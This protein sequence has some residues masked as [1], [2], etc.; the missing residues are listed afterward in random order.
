[1][2]HGFSVDESLRFTVG[3][4]LSV[5][6]KITSRDNDRVK[7]EAE[8]NRMLAFFSV[9]PHIDKESARAPREPKDLYLLP[10]EKKEEQG[11]SVNMKPQTIDEV[12]EWAKKLEGERKLK[13][14][15]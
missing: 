1:M 3:G 14:V 4:A 5:L 8:N 7:I 11:T 10:W 15:S 2:S 13:D 9:A 12:R 6:A